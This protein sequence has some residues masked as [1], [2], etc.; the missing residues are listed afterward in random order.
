ME[1]FVVLEQEAHWSPNLYAS[2]KRP[3]DLITYQSHTVSTQHPIYVYEHRIILSY[4]YEHRIILIPVSQ[5][6]IIFASM[7]IE[8]YLII[9]IYTLTT[10]KSQT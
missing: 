7:N 10:V 5:H 9:Y 4:V 1:F 6:R 2:V 8:L 3:R